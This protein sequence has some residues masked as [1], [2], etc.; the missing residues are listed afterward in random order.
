M[1]YIDAHSREVSL[2]LVGVLGLGLV[3]YL[4]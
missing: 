3:D 1:A 2:W 4:L